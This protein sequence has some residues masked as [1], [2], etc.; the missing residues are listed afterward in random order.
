MESLDD[1]LRAYGLDPKL[2][3]DG[4]LPLRTAILRWRGGVI[5]PCSHCGCKERQVVSALVDVV[6]DECGHTE[7]MEVRGE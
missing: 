2:R 1:V 7:H 3:P 5:T 6:C 4:M